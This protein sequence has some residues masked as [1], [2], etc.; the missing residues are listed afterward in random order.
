MHGSC[1]HCGGPLACFEGETYCPDCSRYQAL[2]LAEE[3][4]DEAR[5]LRQAPAPPPDEGPDGDGP[6][7]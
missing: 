4:D 6:P 1:E 3:A 5:L 2:Q 7:F